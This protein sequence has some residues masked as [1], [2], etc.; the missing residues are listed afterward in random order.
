MKLTGKVALITNVRHYMSPRGRLDLIQP[1]AVAS[2]TS[3][4]PARPITS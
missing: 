2:L 1:R 3:A 4:S